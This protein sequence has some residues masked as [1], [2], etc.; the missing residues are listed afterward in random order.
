MNREQDEIDEIPIPSDKVCPFCEE[1]EFD[2][3][4]LKYHLK[5]GHCKDFEETENI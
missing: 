1:E 2:L 3:S 4:G 5:S